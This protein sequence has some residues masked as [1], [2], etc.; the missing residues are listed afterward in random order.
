MKRRIAGALATLSIAA[1]AASARAYPLDGWEHTGNMRLEAFDLAQEVLLQRGTIRSGALQR[2]D[3]VRLGLVDYPDFKIPPPDPTFSADIRGLLGGDAP[4]YGIAVLDITDPA[5]PFYAEVNGTN[6]QNPGS[7]GK[8][9]VA[10]A[11]FQTLADIHPYDVAARNHA[12]KD[13][14]I[15]ASSLI[16]GDEHAVCFWKPGDSTIRRRILVRG[17]TGNLWTW[18]DW[19]ISASSNGA[20]S[21][22]MAQI[23]ALKHF[24]TAYPPPPA[25]LA[26]YVDGGPASELADNLHE[27]ILGSLRR[28]GIDASQLRQGSPFTKVG[29]ERMPGSLGSTSTA[30]EL[31]HYLTLL[32]QGKLVDPWSSLEIKRLLYLTDIRIRYAAEP[33]LDTSAVYF[34]SGSLYACGG[35]GPCGKYYGNAKNYMNSIA[36]VEYDG[37]GKQLRYI[38]AL[39]SNVLGKN[40]IETHQALARRIHQVIAERHGVVVPPPTRPAETI[41]GQEGDEEG[42]LPS[43]AH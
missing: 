26:S 31:V 32:E 4:A 34:K 42:V 22:V 10:L 16:D 15:E 14:D 21:T 5:H 18:L 11:L 41:G 8:I 9:V 19:M 20:G 12:L 13:S 38:V 6:E 40:S 25:Q 24:G 27:A 36:I 35:R 1:L 3:E 17:D 39:L 2:M 28:N 23:A 29:R 30:R 43:R 37:G 33:T 7:V